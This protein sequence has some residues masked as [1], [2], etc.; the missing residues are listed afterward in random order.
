[1]PTTTAVP[2]GAPPPPSAQQLARG[3]GDAPAPGR[4]VRRYRPED[5]RAGYAFVSPWLLGFVA[6]TA[7]PMLASLYLAFTDYNLFRAPEFVGLD[8]FA[9]LFTDPRFLQSCQV[10]AVYVFVGTPIKLAASLGAALLLN[11][12]HRGQGVYRSI[13]YLPSLIGASVSI[14]IIWRAMFIDDGVVDQIQQLVGLPA[15]GWV[16]NPD[17]TMPMMILLA[18]WTFGAPTVIFLAGLKQVPTELY[19]AAEVDGAGPVRRFWSITVPMLSPVVFFNLLMETISAF[20]VFSSAFIISGGTGGPAGSTL[21]YTLYLYLRGFQDFRMGYAS[22]MAWVLV[23]VV[24]IITAVL[25]RT[26][27]SWVHYTGDVR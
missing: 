24:G 6:L 20:Q 19:E 9:D 21:F 18:V 23:I 4:S 13:F 22:A 15:G 3:E 2:G 25:F 5:T 7:F 14:A 27:R 12:K 26:S 16:G 11:T 17:M 10:T 8:N 1:M